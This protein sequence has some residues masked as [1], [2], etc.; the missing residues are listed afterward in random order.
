M[1]MSANAKVPRCC[2]A[3]A[4]VVALMLALTGAAQS[5]DGAQ[6]PSPEPPP[7]SLAPQPPPA[8]APPPAAP[9]SSSRPGLLDTLGGLL[10]DSADGVSST[11]K[12]THERIQ[13]LNKGTLDTLTSI[14]VA[15]LASG[16][17]LCPRSANGAPDCYAATEKLCKD[18][19]YAVGGRSLDT[20]TSETCNPRIYLPGYKRKE[21]DC[22]VE[23]FVTRAACQ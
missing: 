4:L 13:D 5:Q 16:R 10:R 3:A 9:P 7:A 2:R 22:K 8:E 12:G 18:K 6:P 1:S 17:A 20:E 19:G 14:P 11:L 15:G 21:G 23:T